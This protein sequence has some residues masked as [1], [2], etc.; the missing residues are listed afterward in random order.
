VEFSWRRHLFVQEF[1]IRNDSVELL[2]G[3]VGCLTMRIVGG[4]GQ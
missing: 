1:N 3:F 4:G 2:E